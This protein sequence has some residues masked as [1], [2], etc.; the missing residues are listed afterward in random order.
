MTLALPVAVGIV[1]YKQKILMIKRFRG[2]YQGYL[3]LPGGK[4]ENSEH[5]KNA[6]LR[7]LKEEST[8]ECKFGSF[9]GLVSEIFRNS[10]GEVK[11]FLLN[12]CKVFSKSPDFVSQQEGE[13]DWYSMN[14]IKE[15]K[16]QII[17][18]DYQILKAFHLN[19]PTHSY[20]E[21]F[22]QQTKEEYMIKKF[23]EV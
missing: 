14:R 7:E 10:A 17:P 11:H 18:S 15:L 13:L 1:E 9:L 23:L 22:I 3:A 5:V 12:V 6:M 8:L 4:I 2:D 19:P 20:Y 16:E 21:C